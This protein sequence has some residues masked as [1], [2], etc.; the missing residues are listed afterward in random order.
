[1]TGRS[2]SEQLS[3]GPAPSTGSEK[4]GCR[5]TTCVRCKLIIEKVAGRT[6]CRRCVEEEAVSR[7]WRDPA[8]KLPPGRS[9]VEKES[10][11]K[12][13]KEVVGQD[14]KE[15]ANNGRKVGGVLV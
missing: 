1:M 6:M 5:K 3:V 15:W 10:G 7:G 14:S 13:W 4:L 12:G 9:T 11:W 8:A 2:K